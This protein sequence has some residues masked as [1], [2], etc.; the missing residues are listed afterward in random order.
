MQK[1]SEGNNDQTEIGDIFQVVECDDVEDEG[2][3]ENDKFSEMEVNDI[4]NIHGKRGLDSEKGDPTN[5]EQNEDDLDCVE[6][7]E[8]S[9]KTSNV[10]RSAT[11]S[12]K[13]KS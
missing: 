6:I 8:G 12:G 9:S 2:N 5:K 13:K 11:N 1:R 3:T 10:D 4:D 7:K